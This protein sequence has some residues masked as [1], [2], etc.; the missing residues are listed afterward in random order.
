MIRFYCHDYTGSGDSS[1]GLLKIPSLTQVQ[2]VS[3]YDTSLV[4]MHNIYR[5]TKNNQDAVAD[6]Q[7]S[8]NEKELTYS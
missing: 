6:P 3:T 8:K 1:A 5:R 4:G 2:V 7:Q